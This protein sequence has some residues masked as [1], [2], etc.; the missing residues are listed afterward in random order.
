MPDTLKI[1][2]LISTFN[3]ERDIRPLLN[4]IQMLEANSLEMEVLLRDDAS[5]DDTVN[6]VTHEYAWVTLIQDNRGN[7][8]FVAS[9]NIAF[10]QASGNIICC[11]NQDTILHAG[12][13]SEA[14]KIFLSSSEIAGINTN[15]IM[16]WIMS[17]Q[18]FKNTADADMP[19]HEYQ[20]TKYG[21]AQYS[22]VDKTQH[23][24]SF[25][26]GGG[27]FIRKSALFSDNYLFNPEIDMYCEDTELSLRLQSRGGRIV[28]SPNSIIYHN[29]TS[30]QADKLSEL[31]KLLK[32]TRNRFSLFSTI[33]SPIALTRKYPLLLIGIIKKTSSL[34]LPS[35][36]NV[37]AYIASSGVA[38]IFS[39]LFPY[40]LIQSMQTNSM[41]ASGVQ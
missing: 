11:I 26:T 32:V 20:L 5:T 35:G 2:I 15:M 8:G 30:R 21:F 28:Y 36:K 19:A 38:L 3:G 17:Y 37:I 25:M 27:F 4:S 9:N 10:E 31:L 29:Q 12:F 34:G 7:V 39:F 41:A 14:I 1:S 13:V 40:W 22:S 33:Y 23:S 16:P 24:S 18:Q 6:I